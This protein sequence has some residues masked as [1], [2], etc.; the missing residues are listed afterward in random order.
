MSEAQGTSKRRNSKKRAKAAK[1]GHHPNCTE[2]SGLVK[3]T[4]ILVKK[5]SDSQLG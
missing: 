4:K 2:K 3:L 1:V 5:K